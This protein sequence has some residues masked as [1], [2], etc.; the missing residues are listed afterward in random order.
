MPDISAILKS[1]KIALEKQATDK[2][3]SAVED[4]VKGKLGLGDKTKPLA[5]I[6]KR[7][8]YSWYASSYASALSGGTDYRPKLKF[9]FKVEFIFTPE[10]IAAYPQLKS[11]DFTFMIKSVD[12]PKVDFEYEDDVN[13]YNFRTKVLK[14]IRH[15]ELTVTFMDD[16]GNRVFDFFRTLMFLHSP[17]T[18]RA[19]QR[20]IIDGKK[21]PSP[22]TITEGNGMAFTSAID[23]GK[24]T[25][26]DI[27]HR[28]VINPAFG[29]SGGVGG[30]I[31]CIRVKQMFINPGGYVGPDNVRKIDPQEVI[32]DFLNPRIVSFD[33]DDLTHES[34]D[35]SL[36]TMQFD[37]DWME[38]VKVG[39]LYEADGP[40]YNITVPGITNAPVDTLSGKQAPRDVAQ[41]PKG[42][43]PAGGGN[44][45]LNILT[46]QASRAA[47]KI[48]ADVV[49]KAVKQIAGKGPLGGLVAGA[50]TPIAAGAGSYVNGLVGTGARDLLTG[51]ASAVRG[52]FTTSTR[53]TA[54]DSATRTSDNATII[55]S[56]D[57]GG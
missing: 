52:T 48:T 39:T 11:Q 7:D 46:N 42:V 23:L 28:G 22:L 33:L 9:L 5:K 37:Y 32:Y 15:R 29:Q 57:G 49:N 31:A 41:S 50:L 55:R 2:F 4:F 8:P 17:I 16:T 3:G 21:P 14:K 38:M 45:F 20:E 6:G 18:Q 13:Q 19:L 27:A 34:S 10:A 43:S 12:R 44:P 35:P 30:S 51:A 36:L 47:Q 25:Q 54:S 1:S 26:A 56:T 53:P 24:A 40:T